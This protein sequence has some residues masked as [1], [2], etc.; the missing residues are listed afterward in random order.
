MPIYEYEC[1]DCGYRADEFRMLDD[2]N[3]PGVCPQ[4]GHAL[5]RAFLTAPCAKGP[6]ETD[7]S[8]ENGGRGR[9]IGQLQTTL[10]SKKDSNAYCRSQREAI[11]KASSRGL[12]ASK[13]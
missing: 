12:K 10:G 11:D 6:W 9:Y 3:T 4:C 7:W 5:E 2:R 1:A 13:V 8:N